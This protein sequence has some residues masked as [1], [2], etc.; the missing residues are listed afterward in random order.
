MPFLN[1]FISYP[2]VVDLINLCT[3][4]CQTQMIYLGKYVLHFFVV[5]SLIMLIPANLHFCIQLCHSFSNNNPSIIKY[6]FSLS[7]IEKSIC[8]S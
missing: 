3:S 8:A 7:L 1:V 5:S 2:E 4:V 6:I